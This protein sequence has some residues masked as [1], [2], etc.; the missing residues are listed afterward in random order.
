MPP[1]RRATS[2]LP[3]AN[4]SFT[5]SQAPATVYG[6]AGWLDMTYFDFTNKLLKGQT[7]QIYNYGNFRRNFMYVDNIVEGIVRVMKKVPE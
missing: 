2:C 6:P 1:P 3:I 5:T 7:I 4:R